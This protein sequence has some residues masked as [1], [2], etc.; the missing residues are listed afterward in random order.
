MALFDI[1]DG[2]EKKKRLSH[3]KNLLILSGRDGKVTEDEFELIFSIAVEKGLSPEEFNRI[4]ERPESVS[5][6]P[7]N[8][9]KERIDQLFDLVRLMMIDGEID[10]DEMI[11]CKTVAE[12]LG[13]NHRIIDKI[14]NDII[15][16]VV[17]G[18]AR[19]IAIARLLK[20]LE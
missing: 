1:F 13:F 6:Y 11:F 16:V 15:H 17:Q 18:I 10:E 14:V 19:D 8:S 9:Y 4:L 3:I 5:F 2:S 20:S 12:K 7:P